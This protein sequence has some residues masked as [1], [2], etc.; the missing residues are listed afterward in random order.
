MKCIFAALLAH[1]IFCSVTTVSAD[2]IRIATGH[3]FIKRVFEPIRGPFRDK[4]GLELK[5][6]FKDPLPALA[7]F[8]KGSVDVAGASLTTENWLDLGKNAGIVTGSRNLYSSVVVVTEKTHF[9]VNK[10]N[11]IQ[12]LTKEQLKGI[13]TGRISNWK[14]VG[15][16]DSP[17]LVVWP[18]ISSGTVIIVKQ[19]IMENEP[20]TKALYDVES[21]GD[22]PDAIAATPEAIGVVTGVNIEKGL[23]EISPPIERPLTL[24]YKGKAS[25]KLQ[26]LLDFLNGE[27]KLL[28]Q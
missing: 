1:F 28:I 2:E 8:E 10:A 24:L 3:T 18:T 6:L 26:K 22:V 19:K 12:N 9:V 5:I 20:L 13:F 7:E 25:V 23:K 27:G 21:M 14:E 15:G 11:K 16:D 4:T 17:I